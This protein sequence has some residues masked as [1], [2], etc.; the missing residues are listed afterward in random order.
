MWC[1]FEIPFFRR[2][3]SI[4]IV[5]AFSA[6][7]SYF[8][9]PRLQYTFAVYYI[10][11]GCLAYSN[12]QLDLFYSYPDVLSSYERFITSFIYREK[13]RFVRG[14]S[15]GSLR[16]L[17]VCLPSE[18]AIP[19]RL[20]RRSSP[21]FDA[22]VWSNSQEPEPSYGGVYLLAI[23]CRLH[24]IY[25]PFSVFFPFAVAPAFAVG[26]VFSLSPALGKF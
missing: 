15:N 17:N 1:S 26:I 19:S 21:P 24:R 25:I 18:T 23:F 4:Y 13:G 5:V 7:P 16:G 14:N 11:E 2:R 9:I 3:A 6:G 12:S 8:S 10:F 22:T 20:R